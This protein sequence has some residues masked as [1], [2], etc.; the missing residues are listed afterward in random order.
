MENPEVV[1]ILNHFGTDVA[2]MLTLCDIVFE[3][4]L[5][6]ETGFLDVDEVIDLVIRLKGSRSVHLA[7]VVEQRAYTR[8]RIDRLEEQMHRRHEEVMSYQA[9]LWRETCRPASASR[10]SSACSVQNTCSSQPDPCPRSREIVTL[11]LSWSGK[12][13]KQRHVA[14]LTV[15]ELLAQLHI[16]PL[17]TGRVVAVDE[18]CVEMGPELRL[19]ELPQTVPGCTSLTIKLDE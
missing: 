1:D 19:S 8:S 4:S 18:F 13:K 6:S 9:A 7:D 15:G 11:E 16:E 3:D 12:I 2:G 10:P 17:P 14:S 5:K